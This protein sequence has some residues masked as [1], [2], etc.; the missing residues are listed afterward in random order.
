MLSEQD[1]PASPKF[2]LQ[3][4]AGN[5]VAIRQWIIDKLPNDSFSIDN[6]IIMSNSRRWPLMI[7]PQLQANRWIRNMWADKIKVLKLS[8]SDYA[9]H[10]ENAITMGIPVLIENAITMG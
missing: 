6:G 2:S 10:L 3:E 7:D 9:R 4:V 5:P 8:Q 1:I